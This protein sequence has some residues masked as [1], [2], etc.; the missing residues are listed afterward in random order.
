MRCN[1][2][3]YILELVQ[4]A[5]IYLIIFLAPTVKEMP[6]AVVVGPKAVLEVSF[7]CP[8]VRQGGLWQRVLGVV[9]HLLVVERRL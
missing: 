9:P 3:G 4:H 2:E 6:D 1:M 5:Q 7:H 8:E